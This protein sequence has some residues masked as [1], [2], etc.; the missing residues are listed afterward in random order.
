MFRP[1]I[2]SQL[3]R[4]QGS[5]RKTIIFVESRCRSTENVTIGECHRASLI[6]CP[7]Q[8]LPSLRAKPLPY[9]S[10]AKPHLSESPT[11]SFR[12]I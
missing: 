9:C 11:D 4:S 7:M 5:L 10:P 6:S 1:K 2:D 3:S 12:N 8:C